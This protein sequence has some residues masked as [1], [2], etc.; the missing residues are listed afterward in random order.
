LKLFKTKITFNNRLSS[1]IHRNNTL[2]PK[3]QQ[4]IHRHQTP[5]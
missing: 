5:P 1:Y 4:G 2:K 3:L